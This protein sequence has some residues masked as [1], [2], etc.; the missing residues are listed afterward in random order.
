MLD[1]RGWTEKDFFLL[2]L[3]N[4]KCGVIVNM[5]F[6]VHRNRTAY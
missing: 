6:N 1:F 5:V 3:I 4:G 2:L